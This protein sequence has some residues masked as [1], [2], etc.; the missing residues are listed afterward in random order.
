MTVRVLVSCEHGG[1]R[2]PARFKHLF[3]TPA[4]RRALAGHRGC[5]DG[6]LGVARALA[7]ALG[8]ALHATTITR[9]LVDTNRSPHHRALFSEFSAAAGPKARERMLARYY[10]PH[11]ERVRRAASSAGGGIVVHVGVHSF[12]GRLGGRTRRCDVGLL[13]DPSRALERAFCA[14]WQRLLTAREPSLRVRRNY[15]YRG[16]ADGLTTTLRRELDASRYLGIE[17]E[18]NRERLGPAAPGRRRLAAAIVA[19][20]RAALAEH[21]GQAVERAR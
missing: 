6:A 17:L 7:R 15:P 3:E 1:R 9:L 5:D 11:R 2:V 12:A 13:Y 16:A 4:A 21:N 10:L 20:L 14:R 8:V 18:I 19:S